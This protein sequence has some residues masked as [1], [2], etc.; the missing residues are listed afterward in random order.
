MQIERLT[1]AHA[2]EYRTLA[3]EGY[4]RHPEAFTSTADERA[5]LPL[6]WWQRRLQPG[7]QAS[8]VFFGARIDDR[9]VGVAGLSFEQRERNRHKSVLVGM[10]VA[11]AARGRGAAAAS[12][13][14]LLMHARSRPGARLM[15]LTVTEGN[16]AARRLYE[17]HGF[18]AFGTEPLS[19]RVGERYLSKVFM[20]CDLAA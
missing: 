10:Y 1:A 11:P 19:I 3:L 14:A 5:A 8:E 4:A 16:D 9:L 13:D 18:V 17:R 15:V 6:D 2:G 12:V 20:A 7:D